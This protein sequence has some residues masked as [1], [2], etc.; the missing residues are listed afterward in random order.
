[1]EGEVILVTE[2]KRKRKKKK[3]GKEEKSWFSK[4]INFYFVTV[5]FSH[6]QTQTVM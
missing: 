3:K 2:E 4:M 5:H 6:L 1:M